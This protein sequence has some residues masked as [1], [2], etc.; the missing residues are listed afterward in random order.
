MISSVLA[1]ASVASPTL[2]TLVVVVGLSVNKP[3]PEIVADQ[4]ISFA[5][6][7]KFPM[8]VNAWVMEI[9]PVPA[10]SDK[11][12]PPPAMALAIEILPLLALLLSVKSSSNVIVVLPSP[13]AINPTPAVALDVVMVPASWSALEKLGAKPPVTIVSVS[14]AASPT[15]STPLVSKAVVVEKLLILLLAPVKVRSYAALASV[16]NCVTWREPEKVTLPAVLLSHNVPILVPIAP[17][18]ETVPALL[19]VIFAVPETGP[20]TLATLILPAALSPSVKVTAF[21][22]LI[23]PML[24]S[25]TPAPKSTLVVTFVVRLVP[26]VIPLYVLIAPA[27]VL[28]PVPTKVK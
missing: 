14:L 15:V 2:I 11:A 8:P 13:S 19:K 12:L 4:S 6:K 22:R 7:L 9:V 23:A 24:I 25:P 3:V 18:T 10:F 17:L 1:P 16:L 26:K 27:I 28:L 20:V 21:N 5:V